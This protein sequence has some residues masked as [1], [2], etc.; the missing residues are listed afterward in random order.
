VQLARQLDAL[1]IDDPYVA[2][3]YARINAGAST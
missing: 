3:L 2:Q 1:D